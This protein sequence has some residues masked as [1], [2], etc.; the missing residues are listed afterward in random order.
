MNSIL[1]ITTAELW[2]QSYKKLQVYDEQERKSILRRYFEDKW[3]FNR[4]VWL[5]P[6]P[7]NWNVEQLAE[8]DRDIQRINLFEPIQHIIG[9]TLF[10]ASKI[11]VNKDV[12]IPRPETEELVYRI[13]ESFREKQPNTIIDVCTGSGCIALELKRNFPLAHVDAVDISEAAL[14]VANRN[15][16]ENTLNVI[17]IQDDILHPAL[18][19][20]Q[21]DIIVSNP[22]YIPISEKKEM[23]E[24]VVQY[25][26]H[27]ALFVADEEALVFYNALLQF[28]FQHLNKGGA[29]WAEIHYNQKNALLAL[30]H[31]YEWSTCVIHD[32]HFGRNRFLEVVK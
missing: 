12:L 14:H 11:N 9:Y 20:G 22:P 1:P 19:Y 29:L 16:M 32:D 10:G 13:V 30:A 26:P 18:K 5:M 28:A 23:L 25:E 24:N 4:K 7:L 27:L 8:V 21:Y 31:M 2:Q 3:E 17:W 6:E 15:A